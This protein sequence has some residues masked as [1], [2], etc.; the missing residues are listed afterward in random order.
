MITLKHTPTGSLLLSRPGATIRVAPHD[1]AALAQAI[2]QL[3][4]QP[5]PTPAQLG[6]RLAKARAP[7]LVEV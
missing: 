6:Q 3:A 1:V 7:H 4:H 5:A 2:V